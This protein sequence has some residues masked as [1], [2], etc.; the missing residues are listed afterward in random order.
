[1]NSGAVRPTNSPLGIAAFFENHQFFMPTSNHWPSL[2]LQIIP[3]RIFFL[4]SHNPLLAG[5]GLRGARVAWMILRSLSE[6]GGPYWKWSD[7]A[8]LET[9]IERPTLFC[10]SRSHRLGNLGHGQEER[11]WVSKKNCHNSRFMKDGGFLKEFFFFSN[12]EFRPRSWL[13]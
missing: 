5:T 2:D 1:M 9:S 11:K 10:S 7:P 3:I 4:I 6:A 12:S 8:N 13:Y